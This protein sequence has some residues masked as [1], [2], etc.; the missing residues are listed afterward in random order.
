MLHTVEWA[1]PGIGK[2]FGGSARS[3][4]GTAHRQQAILKL[5]WHPC[6]AS[7]GRAHE[8]FLPGAVKSR[9]NCDTR[10]RLPPVDTHRHVTVSFEGANVALVG[11]SSTL[12]YILHMHRQAGTSQELDSSLWTA[13]IHRV[14]CGSLRLY[15]SLADTGTG[16]IFVS[17]K[18]TI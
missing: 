10:S 4:A 15:L 12:A 14:L 9:Q 11:G 7:V 3:Q 13:A 1:A 18:Q 6:L 5:K 2:C 8:L 17:R 16:Y